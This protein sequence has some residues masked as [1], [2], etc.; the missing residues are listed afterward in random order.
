MA[1]IIALNKKIQQAQER[2]RAEV[3]KRK[4]EAVRNVLQC[5]RCA[6]KCEKCG[7]HL[8]ENTPTDPFRYKDLKIPYRLCG[9][10]S[11]EYRDY[12]KRLQGGGDPNCYWHNQAWLESWGTWIK[13]RGTVDRYL[14][15]KEF[16]RLLEELK[17]E[18]SD[19]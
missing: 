9:S 2:R 13:Y 11:L 12:I 1:D 14:Q 3:R 19:G 6:L 15:S 16:S 5:S 8:D 4:L 18:P 7:T 10:C 17:Q